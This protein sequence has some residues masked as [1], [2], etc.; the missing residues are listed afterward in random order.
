METFFRSTFSHDKISQPTDGQPFSAL[1]N[2]TKTAGA[3][4]YFIV[5]TVA[6]YVLAIA[7]LIVFIKFYVAKNGRQ[8]DEAKDKLVRNLEVALALGAILGLTTTV[9]A[10]FIW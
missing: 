5:F 9:F 10:V 4:T 2:L 7:T 3:T 6:V 8:R 1:F